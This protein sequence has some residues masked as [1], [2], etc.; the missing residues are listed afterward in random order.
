MIMK[1][2]LLLPLLLIFTISSQASIKGF[3]TDYNTAVKKAASSNK[4]VMMVFTG[5]DWCPPCIMMEKQ[6]N[7]HRMGGLEG[8]QRF[9]SISSKSSSE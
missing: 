6:K 7:S 2:F 8:S 4:N 1:K 3:E 5:S 9:F